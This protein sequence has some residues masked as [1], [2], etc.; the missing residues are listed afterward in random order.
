MR[1]YLLPLLLLSACD[2]NDNKPNPE[3][4]PYVLNQHNDERIDNYYWMRDDTR[5][6][7]KVLSYLRDENAYTDQW[8]AAR[9][10]YKKD[11]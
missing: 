1:F 3:Q 11:S 5:S 6:S 9:N 10:N 7:E 8:F 4:I 2:M